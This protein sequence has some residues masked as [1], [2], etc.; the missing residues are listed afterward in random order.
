[1]PYLDQFS[2]ESLLVVKKPPL[3]SPVISTKKLQ[4]SNNTFLE[5]RFV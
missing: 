5:D 1:M 4:N 2:A 3:A